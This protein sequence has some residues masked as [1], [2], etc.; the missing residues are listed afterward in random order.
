MRVAQNAGSQ[1]IA[2][3][4]NTACVKGF[5]S[6]VKRSSTVHAR[7]IG[8][9]YKILGKMTKVRTTSRVL[10]GVRVAESDS[11]L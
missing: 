4:W 9:E 8:D 5:I 7:L 11:R 2:A 3:N 6:T 10:A 1:E